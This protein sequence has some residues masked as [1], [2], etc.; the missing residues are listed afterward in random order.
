MAESMPMRTSVLKATKAVLSET[1]SPANNVG[2]G[3]RLTAEQMPNARTRPAN[4]LMI[5]NAIDSRKNSKRI[6]RKSVV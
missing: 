6:D 1:G 4:P 2:S 3:S 5:V